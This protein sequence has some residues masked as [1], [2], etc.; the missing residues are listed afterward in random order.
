MLL[1]LYKNHMAIRFPLYLDRL[2]SCR[3]FRTSAYSPT[4]SISTVF[5]S[6][7]GSTCLLFNQIQYN[8]WWRSI[9][10][11]FSLSFI[12]HWLWVH[13]LTMKC[14]HFSPCTIPTQRGTFFL[15]HRS[16]PWVCFSITE[17]GLLNLYLLQ[18][19]IN[20]SLIVKL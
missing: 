2:Q 4:D 6:M 10:T 1:I 11:L 16:Y 14:E 17:T 7:L 12:E 19:W 18:S 20:P 15:V 13:E 9:N 5:S 3:M 8:T